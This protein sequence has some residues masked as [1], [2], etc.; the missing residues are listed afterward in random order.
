M[1]IPFHKPIFP[2]DLNS[3]LGQSTNSGWVTTGPKVKE[4]ETQLSK[5]FRVEHVVAVNS[6]TAALHLAL[7][8]KG[9]GKGDKFIVPTYTFVASVEV[10]EY[11][12]A[13]P[14]LVDS[15]P[16]TFNLD[17]DKVEEI[18]SYDKSQNNFNIISSF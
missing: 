10:G 4:F 11:L 13:E 1:K 2:S 6:G 14:V 18:L 17:L 5:Y 12:G 15:D 3:L 9:I 8:A 16:K 7:A